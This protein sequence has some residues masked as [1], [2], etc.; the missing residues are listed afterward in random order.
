M[1]L[2]V[3]AYVAGESGSRIIDLDSNLATAVFLSESEHRAFARSTVSAKRIFVSHYNEDSELARKI[4]SWIRNFGM[5]AF[6]DVDDPDLPPEDGADLAGYIKRVINESHGLV[7]VT[8]NKTVNSWWVP[9]EIGV[10]DQKDLVLATYILDKVELPS[11]LQKWPMLSNK[12]NL[13]C[14]CEELKSRGDKTLASFYE[15]LEQNH[16]SIYA[17]RRAP[18]SATY[19]RISI[20]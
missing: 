11:Y 1:A 18:R 8:S 13:G 14:W 5:T 7:V 4:A 10:A 12:E 20:R 6:L 9:Y 17:H 19:G 15:S 2:R 16:P 3:R